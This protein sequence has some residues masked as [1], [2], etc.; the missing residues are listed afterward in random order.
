MQLVQL[1]LQGAVK[2]FSY[3]WQANMA[4]QSNAEPAEQ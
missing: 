3:H 1:N 2:R 4:H